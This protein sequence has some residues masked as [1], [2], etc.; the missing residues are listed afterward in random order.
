MEPGYRL[1]GVAGTFAML[2]AALFWLRRRGWAHFSSASR[3]CATKRLESLEKIAV[4]PNQWIHL[5]RL[6]DRAMVVSV[7]PSGCRFL[8]R[9]RLSELDD[10]AALHPQEGSR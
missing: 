10:S 6:G 3:R 5:L 4:G 9:M 2:G 8:A 7:S 1:L